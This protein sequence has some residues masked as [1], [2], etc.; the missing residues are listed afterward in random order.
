LLSNFTAALFWSKIVLTLQ[1]TNAAEIVSMSTEGRSVED[2]LS[3]EWLLTNQ[4]GSYASSTIVGCNT[5]R[6]HG[7]LIGSLNPPANRIMALAKC[8]EMLVLNR[9]GTCSESRN[10]NHARVFNLSTFEFDGKFAPV[11]SGCMKRFRQDTGVHFDFQFDGFELTKSVYLLRDT[12]TVALVYDFTRV[13]EP[14]EFI[15]R[16]FIG[17]RDFHTLQKSYA[18]LYSRWIQ[19]NG[20]AIPA[21]D[22][23]GPGLLIRHDIPGSP[24]SS[25]GLILSIAMIRKEARILQRICGRPAFLKRV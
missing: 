1:K 16:P 6:Y 4:R 10:G 14:A 5:R 22:H 17:L 24:I 15:L 13:K 25:G 23:W 9:A 21:N 12:D 11:S 2:L 7:L 19:G 8:L 18:P 20:A 3:K